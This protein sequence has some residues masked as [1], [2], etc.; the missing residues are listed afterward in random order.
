[1][2]Q[3]LR[4]IGNDNLQPLRTYGGYVGVDRRLQKLYGYSDYK[5]DDQYEKY[6]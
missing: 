2:N 1:M 4:L 3:I 5:I 6:I